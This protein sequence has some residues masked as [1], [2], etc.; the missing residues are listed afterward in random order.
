MLA[1][2]LSARE[3]AV[4]LNVRRAS[5][6]GLEM[7]CAWIVRRGSETSLRGALSSEQ[8]RPR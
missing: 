4:N 3:A 7:A 1:R 6:R 2:R 8:F 5:R